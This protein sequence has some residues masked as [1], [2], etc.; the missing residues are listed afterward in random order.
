MKI[1]KGY[2][3][4][5]DLNNKQKTACAQHAG[6][7]RWAYNWGLN[8][9][10]EHYEQ[11]KKSIGAM[12]LHKELNQLKQTSIRWMYDVSKCAPQE[13][14]R[15]LDKAFKGFFDSVT[16]KRKGEPAGFPK[17][18]SKRNGLGSFRL[19]GSIK[20]E[21]NRVRLPRLGWLRLKEFGYI[22]V[23]S[24][25]ILSATVS[26]KSSRWFVSIQ[27][28]E[29]IPDPQP[30]TGTP[31]G[32]DLGIKTMA[33]C[34]DGTTFDNPKALYA[35]TKQLVRWQRRLSRRIKGSQNWYKA[36]QKVAQLHMDIANLRKD[37][38]H[39]ATSAIMGKRPSHVVIENLNI[40]GMV[41]N[42]KLAKAVSDVGMGEFG[43]QIKYK[44]KWNGIETIE[45]G[46][47]Y[48]SSKTCSGCSIVK[49]KLPL[50]ART[51]NCDSCGLNI[52]RDLNAAVNLR[53]LASV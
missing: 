37:T 25:H 10:K 44:T 40:K 23:E 29:E 12:V 35:R 42:R 53:Q 31:I 51:Y 5:L 2:K 27:V 20:V 49:D 36:K 50:S 45:A 4:E 32:V 22:P 11:T 26:E 7:A 39:K 8:R 47:F 52:D 38:I 13:A 17:F 3:V 41:K 16:G 48:P 34:S 18:K 33:T 46:R 14:L 24:V 9:K 43:R 15:N 30:V 1:V 21:T 6:A 19:T 28:E